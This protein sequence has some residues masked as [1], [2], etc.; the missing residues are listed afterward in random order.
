MGTLRASS[1]GSW[2][3]VTNQE[4]KRAFALLAEKLGRVPTPRDKEWVE[5]T[6]RLRKSYLPAEESCSKYKVAHS[7]A[8]SAEAI[9]GAN[10]TTQ[11]ATTASHAGKPSPVM[12]AGRHGPMT[13]GVGPQRRRPVPEMGTPAGGSPVSNAREDR[14][15]AL[16]YGAE[17]TDDPLSRPGTI[18]NGEC[19]RTTPDPPSA[20]G[21]NYSTA[22][23]GARGPAGGV[24]AECVQCHR[25]WE[26]PKQRGRPSA[27]CPE[28]ANT[29]HVPPSHLSESLQAISDAVL[30]GQNTRTA[31][32]QAREH[33]ATWEDIGAWF[34]VSKQAAHDRFA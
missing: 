7:G 22:L 18:P 8:M 25:V 26:R 4:Y 34:G 9:N 32:D 6:E 30:K 11:T 14:K 12:S 17:L 3:S 13:T 28:C 21:F 1:C 29:R 5:L 19:D 2:A 10:Q 33:G 31:V 16:G 27:R 24:L 20:P 23:V 15:L